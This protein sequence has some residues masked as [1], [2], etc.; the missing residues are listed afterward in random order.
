[1]KGTGDY[2]MAKARIAI[3]IENYAE[4]KKVDITTHDNAKSIAYAAYA[5]SQTKNVKGIVSVTKSGKTAENISCFRPNMP[6]V[7]CTPS[8]ETYHKLSMFYAVHPILDQKYK[9]INELNQKSLE[10][11]LNTGLFHKNDKVVLVSG[12]VADKSGASLMA[13]KKL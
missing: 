11:S 6:I 3:E 8:E 5:L 9:D 1:M 7:A 13:V 2:P 4:P 10:K 12:V